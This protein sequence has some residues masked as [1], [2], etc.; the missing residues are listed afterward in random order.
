MKVTNWRRKLIASL[1]A[2]GLL[3]PTAASAA[4]LNTNLVSN[5]GFESV[6]FGTVGDYGSPTVQNWLG[7]PGFAYSHNPGVTM[8]PDYAD[9][10]DPP[11]AGNWYFTSNN[12]PGSE[13][14]DWRAPELVYQDIDVSGGATGARIASGEA[15]VKLTAWMGSYLNDNDNG[16]VQVDFKNTG[17]TTTGSLVISDGDF[18][19]NNVWSLSA[20]ANAVPAGTTSLRVSVF[21]TAR[22]G[23]A[24]GYIDNVDV[25]IVQP[26]VIEVNTTNGQVNLKNESGAT[27]HIDYYEITSA[28]GAL[29]ATAWNSLQEQN[30]AGFPA[31]NGSGN[32]WEQF[33]GSRGTILGESYLTG[34]SAVANNAAI[35]L[36]AAFNV[37]GA[38]D[39]VFRYGEIAGAVPPPTGDYSDNGTVDAADFV[40]WRDKLNQ[41]VTL[42]NDS[43]PG[44]VTQADLD[45]WRANF[46]QSG[47]PTG[48]SS[49]FP[50]IVR[51]VTSGSASAVPEPATTLLVGIGLVTIAAAT[52]RKPSMN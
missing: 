39:L 48:T 6:D 10:A 1:A 18:G 2:G 22:N 31:G 44:T 25:R 7:G 45:I 52:G 12:N 43:T 47:G 41:N 38:R 14:G 37:G 33:G 3:A 51:Y 11:G 27:A 8:I 32:G 21:G 5:P 29:N 30:L 40:A 35:G 42:P 50:G 34:N 23:G 24:D 13:T 36:G 19:P 28:A 16:N 49:L 26:L 15:F 20:G 9:G 4:E 17:G 46:G